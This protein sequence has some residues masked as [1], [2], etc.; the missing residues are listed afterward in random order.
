MDIAGCEGKK[1]YLTHRHAAHDA[2]EM[3][4]KHDN[5]A[6]VYRCRQAWHVGERRLAKLLKPRREPPGFDMEGL[7]S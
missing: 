3:L 4:R 1:V 5:H 2:S 6:Q 7:D